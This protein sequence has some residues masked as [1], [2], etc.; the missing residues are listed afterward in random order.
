MPQ[1]F[2]VREKVTLGWILVV[3]VLDF[4]QILIDFLIK[5]TRT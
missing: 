1:L 4:G 5:H 3:Q 2:V